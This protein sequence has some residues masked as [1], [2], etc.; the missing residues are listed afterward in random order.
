MVG[1]VVAEREKSP[2]AGPHS[3]FERRTIQAVVQVQVIGEAVSREQ[4]KNDVSRRAA[5]PAFVAL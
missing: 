2:A 1:R 3:R 5:C 4:T